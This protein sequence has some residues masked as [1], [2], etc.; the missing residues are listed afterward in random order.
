MMKGHKKEPGRCQGAKR[1]HRILLGAFILSL[2]LPG[3]IQAGDES[4]S[5]VPSGIAGVL[6]SI[7][8]DAERG[9]SVSLVGS[10]CENVLVGQRISAPAAGEQDS[11]PVDINVSVQMETALNRYTSSMQKL[12]SAPKM[13]SDLDYDTL[14][15]IVQAEAG[16]EDLKGKILVANVI[17]N[18]V[19]RDD[20]PDTVYE[21]VYQN[22]G[23]VPQFQPT[24]DGRIYR[25]SVT[26]ET[27]EAVRQALSGVDYSEGALF[28]MAKSAS[29][30]QS[31]KW[32]EKDLKKLFKYGYHE[33]YTIPD[34][35]DMVKA[36]EETAPEDVQ[37]AMA[38]ETGEDARV[39][40]AP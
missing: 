24:Y 7:D 3:T 5:D 16:I 11:V 21:V 6:A 28:F 15:R 32:F 35:V 20:F 31:V 10:S 8:L 34:T 18:R 36:D 12:A 27:R 33:F 14:L 13:M 23:G 1:V 40:Q 37:T 9:G 22:T 39:A 4:L 17:M 30:E 29:E 26:D 19:A 38:S 2:A 25:V